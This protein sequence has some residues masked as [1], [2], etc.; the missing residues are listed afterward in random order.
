[1]SS[2]RV[3]IEYSPFGTRA[4]GAMPASSAA[5]AICAAASI[6]MVPCSRSSNS[7]SNPADFIAMAIST[8]RVIRT[9]QPSDSSP[10][11]SRSR[12]ILLMGRH[13]R[14]LSDEFSVP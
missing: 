9:P 13:G 11:S 2:S 5:V 8:L 7:Q 12:A 4:S 10:F 14:F 3:A 6:D 1:M